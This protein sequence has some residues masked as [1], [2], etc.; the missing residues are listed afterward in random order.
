MTGGDVVVAFTTGPAQSTLNYDATISNVVPGGYLA[1]ELSESPC[2]S[3]SSRHCFSDATAT[4]H[5]AAVAVSPSTTYYLWVADGY[6]SD[7]RPDV[8]V[9][10]W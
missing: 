8:S 9:C 7:P 1:V 2:S 5:T 10:V 6:A 3:G 4:S